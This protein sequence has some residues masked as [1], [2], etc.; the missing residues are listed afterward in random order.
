MDF[1]NS[2]QNLEENL[3]ENYSNPLFTFFFKTQIAKNEEEIKEILEKTEKFWIS[4]TKK[5]KKSKEENSQKEIQMIDFF[6]LNLIVKNSIEK[7]KSFQIQN[8]INLKF[9]SILKESGSFFSNLFSFE[10]NPKKRK[11]EKE[12]ESILSNNSFNKKKI[13]KIS[14][15]KRRKNLPFQAKKILKEFFLENIENPYPSK[16]EKENLSEKTGLSIRQINTWFIN[17][18]RR[19]VKKENN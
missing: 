7:I 18:R 13:E 11:K 5:N 6:L 17:A 15:K 4:K 14:L 1:F 2:K 10:K 9:E 16:N 19:K 3:I 12:K 8:E